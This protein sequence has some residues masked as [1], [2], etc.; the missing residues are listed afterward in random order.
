LRLLVA[1]HDAD[2]PGDYAVG[3]S[4][5]DARRGRLGARR[6]RRQHRHRAQALHRRPASRSISAWAHDLSETCSS[7]MTIS[8]MAR[9][10]VLDA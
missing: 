1:H 3:V 9:F 8:Q 6:E 10:S 4:R 2:R 7:G 5:L